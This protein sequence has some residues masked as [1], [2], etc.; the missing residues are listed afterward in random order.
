MRS[1]SYHTI[2]VNIPQGFWFPRCFGFSSF[3]VVV[4]FAGILARI[5]P[6]KR[7]CKPLS[8][9]WRPKKPR[10][11]SEVSHTNKKASAHMQ[12]HFTSIHTQRQLASLFT[13]RRGLL[14]IGHVAHVSKRNTYLE[15]MGQMQLFCLQLEASCLQWTL[16]TCS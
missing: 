11:I 5:H 2:C 7:F 12:A 3:L 15:I 14:A 6:K 16:C 1:A 13:Y 8:R 10:R 4:I 9:T